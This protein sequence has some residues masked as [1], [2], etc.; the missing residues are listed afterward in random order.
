MTR[1]SW[2]ARRARWQRT[3]CAA[4]A[5]LIA[6]IGSAA[7]ATPTPC[8]T[9]ADYEPVETRCDG[10][11]NDCDGLVDFLLP[12][13]DNECHTQASCAVGHATCSGG[14]RACFAPGP[15]PEVF[16]GTDNDCNGVVDDVPPARTM[17][18]ALLLVPGYVFG[19]GPLEID[20]IASML[21]Q[22]GIAYDRPTSALDFDV[23][24][25]TLSMYPLVII[26]G[27]LEEDFLTPYRQAEL[28]AYA[29]SGG[30]LVIYKPIF[31]PGSRTHSLTGTSST[32][33]RS[34]V[35]TLVFD[36]PTAVATGAFDSPEERTLPLRDPASNDLSYVHL[37]LPADGRTVPLASG[38]RAGA[39]LGPVVLRRAA[40]LGAVYSLGHDLH[41]FS[42]TRCYVNCFEPAGDL[43]GL[44]LREAFREGTHG[45]VVLKHTVPGLEDSVAILSHDV[46]ALD[47]QQPGPEWGEPG[48]LQVASLESQHGARG[49]F[50]FTTAYVTTSQSIAYYSPTLTQALCGL[51]MCPVGA[52][53][54]M[55]GLD[56]GQLPLGS[57]TETAASY[58]PDVSPTLCGEVQVSIELLTRALGAAPV[59]WRSPY[60]AINPAQYDLLEAQGILYDSSYAVGDLKFNLPL[61]LAHTGKNQY[62]FHSRALYSMPIALED[63]LG[64]SVEG[65][66]QREEMSA[67]NA[68]KFVTLWS[69]AMQRNADNHAHTLSLLHP[70]YGQ[71]APQDNVRNKLQVLERYIRACQARGVKVD[72]TMGD[73]AEFWRAREELH[74]D[75]EYVSSR[76]QG[77]IAV[78]SHSVRDLTLEFGD[79]IRSFSGVSPSEVQIADRRVVLRG[80]LPPNRVYRFSASVFEPSSNPVPSTGIVAFV[81]LAGLLLL[82]GARQARQPD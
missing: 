64:G 14:V 6:Q 8:P 73:I 35:E 34:D 81:S 59:A 23:A 63:G 70:S 82:L 57:C 75:A 79:R 17:A 21:D 2:L 32:V 9:G 30:I 67:A 74:V 53:S 48:A 51:G 37:L 44:F 43:S 7:A 76:Y 15:T 50:L 65:A 38:Y 52:H 3:L 60:L 58:Q 16:D 28:E 55:H 27:Y 29:Q 80:L 22:W 24:L 36:G 68:A 11:D 54:V 1:A 66:A 4:L 33:R 5:S 56:F 39:A 41:S 77:S 40:G 12:T 49:S 13:A 78:G 19:D 71:S 26:P 45:H 25:P 69:Y 47:A 42:A 18:R 20:N 62:L 31:D 10:L 61:S 72:A 46:D